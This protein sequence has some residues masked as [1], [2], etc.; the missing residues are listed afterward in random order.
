MRGELSEV[1]QSSRTAIDEAK[2]DV[3]QAKRNRQKAVKAAAESADAHTAISHELMQ[4]HLTLAAETGRADE[5]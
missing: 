4:T 3:E 5:A 2:K 1:K